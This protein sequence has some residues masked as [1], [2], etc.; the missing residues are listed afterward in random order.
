MESFI[1]CNECHI[2][3]RSDS[4][5]ENILSLLH[6]GGVSIAITRV[7]LINGGGNSSGCSGRGNRTTR[8]LKYSGRRTRLS[9]RE[10]SC[11]TD[12]YLFN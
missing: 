8:V 3:F 7:D 4:S 12:V 10:F 9:E 11:R 1:N 5:N 6:S 2:S